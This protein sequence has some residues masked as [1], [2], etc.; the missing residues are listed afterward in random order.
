MIEI[1]SYQPGVRDAKLDA[2]LARSSEFTPEIEAVVREIVAAV[3]ARG[4]EALAE[5]TRKFDGVDLQP[6]GFRVPEAEIDA[7]YRAVD[8]DLLG[9]LRE[10]AANI[11]R[12]HEAQRRASWFI[13]DGD[14][15]IL[16]KRVLPIGRV[17]ILIPGASAPLF[18]TL[19]MAA[20]PAQVAEVPQ[21][22][23]ATPPQADGAVR[24]AVLAAARIAGVR[25]IYRVFGAQAVAAL[26]YGTRA[27][28]KVDKI[29]GPG[30]PYVQT[31]KK[32][33]F[34]TVGIDA[35][36]GPSEIVVLAD[37]SADPR[38][39][40]ADLLSQ[41]EHGSGF[42]ASVCITPSGA[43]AQKV[44]D[45]VT[46][47][48]ERLPRS[49]AIR[50]ALDNF[51]AIVVVPD[52]DVGVDLVNRIAPEHVELLVARPWEWLDR[53]RNAGAV[54]LGPAS[55]EPVGDYFAGTN[56]ILPTNGAARFASSLSVDDFLKTISVVAYTEQRLAKTAGKIVK[57]ADA[58]GL[59]AHAAAI[60]VRFDK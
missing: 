51:G 6:E 5:Y 31:A 4:D 47:Q 15:V 35:L 16:G 1:V 3:R 49:G 53:I 58:E 24:P 42:E 8:P 38:C 33:V 50:K 20:I 43:L 22:C 12:F 11:R 41:A 59:E 56:H 48:A 30:N 34:G 39:V 10:A 40:A 25:E 55:S 57:L 9:A 37:A 27:I 7:A 60:R 28:P 13:E 32:L 23:V 2:I 52:L 54:F 14:G 18:S 17:A 44:R 36:A 19:L 45:E 26:A 46:R 29:V 21:V